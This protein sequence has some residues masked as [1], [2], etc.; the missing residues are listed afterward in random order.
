MR[1]R[2]IVA[3]IAVATKEKCVLDGSC[4]LVAGMEICDGRWV[5]TVLLS[6]S[7]KDAGLRK[8]A[9]VATIAAKRARNAEVRD[10]RAMRAR[11]G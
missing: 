11:A 1:R 2:S 6:H 7:G 8:D 9:P 4:P 5:R 10:T 3:A